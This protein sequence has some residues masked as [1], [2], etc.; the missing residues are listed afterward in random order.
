MPDLTCERVQLAKNTI[1]ELMTKISHDELMEQKRLDNAD[2][3]NKY[4]KQH[5][6][7]FSYIPPGHGTFFKSGLANV[8]H[9]II[10]VINHD[11]TKHCITYQQSHLQV[12]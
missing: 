11:K 12:I 3:S 5:D 1:K 7:H 6:N 2:L 9:K 8:F 10:D 4:L